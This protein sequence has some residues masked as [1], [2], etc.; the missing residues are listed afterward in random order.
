MVKFLDLPPFFRSN[1]DIFLSNLG[2]PFP[3]S[4]ENIR[5]IHIMILFDL[6]RVSDIT[7]WSVEEHCNICNISRANGQRRGENMRM[8]NEID[9]VTIIDPRA[10]RLN[11][12]STPSSMNIS[13]SSSSSPTPSSKPAESR[14]HDRDRVRHGHHFRGRD[15]TE[16]DLIVSDSTARNSKECLAASSRP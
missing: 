3:G 11:E 6:R 2:Y 10:P 13:S 9:R 15:L 7:R 14:W 1:E 5:A 4:P 8:R 12:I 16:K